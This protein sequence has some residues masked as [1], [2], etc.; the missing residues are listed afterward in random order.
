MKQALLT[1]GLVLLPTMAWA[2]CLDLSEEGAKTLAGVISTKISELEHASSKPLAKPTLSLKLVGHFDSTDTSALSDGNDLE[3]R[4]LA[5]AGCINRDKLVRSIMIGS[6]SSGDSLAFVSDETDTLVQQALNRI[7]IIGFGGMDQS[8]ASQLLAR[9]INYVVVIGGRSRA[10]K[11]YCT[12]NFFF[13]AD[14]DIHSVGTRQ[15]VPVSVK[16][17]P[18]SPSSPPRSSYS[19][20]DMGY[21]SFSVQ[22]TYPQQIVMKSKSKTPICFGEVTVKLDYVPVN[23]D[24]WY[25][26]KEDVSCILPGGKKGLQ[27]PHAIELKLL[28]VDPKSGCDKFIIYGFRLN[29]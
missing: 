9:N 15:I 6:Q 2:D 13:D 26:W 17:L 29:K 14:V 28:R 25:V 3:R 10:V 4:G 7:N 19:Q 20:E 23:Y 12:F 22:G 24:E 8:T 1:L 21:L 16:A 11:Y 27:P 5:E 18:F